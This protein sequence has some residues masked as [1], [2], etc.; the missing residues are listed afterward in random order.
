[1]CKS[2]DANDKKSWGSKS[3][4]CKIH[5]MCKINVTNLIEIPRIDVITSQIQFVD[6]YCMLSPLLLNVNHKFCSIHI[7]HQEALQGQGQE[8]HCGLVHCSWMVQCH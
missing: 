5:E 8:G 1:M 2:P 4:W 7:Q 3:K 6:L